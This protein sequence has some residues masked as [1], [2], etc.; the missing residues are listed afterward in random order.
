MKHV[1]CTTWYDAICTVWDKYK[2]EDPSANDIYIVTIMCSKVIN[3]SMRDVTI[4]IL[5]NMRLF[6]IVCCKANYIMNLFYNVSRSISLELKLF[7]NYTKLGVNNADW[8]SK[9][10]KMHKN[11]WKMWNYIIQY[12]NVKCKVHWNNSIN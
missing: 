9:M 10:L 12:C 11:N 2:Q 8:I 7:Y 5:H 3:I 4:N 6:I 1:Q